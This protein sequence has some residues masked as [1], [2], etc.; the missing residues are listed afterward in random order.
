MVISFDNKMAPDIQW[1]RNQAITISSEGTI[2]KFR[3]LCTAFG[4]S[5]LALESS[6][7]HWNGCYDSS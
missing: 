5:H 7:R 1:W 4:G 3:V 6:K 2:V